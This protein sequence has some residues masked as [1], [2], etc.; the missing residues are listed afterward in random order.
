MLVLKCT[1]PFMI[2]RVNVVLDGNIWFRPRACTPAHADNLSAVTTTHN[3]ARHDR[4]GLI[5]SLHLHAIVT[6]A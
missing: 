3:A 1:H 4:V 5:G 2:H 6:S